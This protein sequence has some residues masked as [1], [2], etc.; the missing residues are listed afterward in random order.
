MKLQ[1][2]K[3]N[4]KIILGT[5]S[6]FLIKNEKN[7]LLNFFKNLSEH[8]L[9]RIDTSP[10]YSEGK[11]QEIIGQLLKSGIR[12][13]ITTKVF[14][15][16]NNSG[17][18]G[19]NKN[20]ILNSLNFSLNSLN[21]KK[22]DRLLMHDFDKNVSLSELSET[23][24]YLFEKN[25][26]LKVGFCKWNYKNINQILKLLNINHNK[27][28]VQYPYSFLNK[29]YESD[30]IFCKQRKLETEVY[31]IF[32]QGSLLGNFNNHKDEVNYSK[33]HHIKDPKA[34]FEYEKLI[35]LFNNKDLI[36]KKIIDMVL[37]NHFI[38]NVII[39]FSKAE[40]ING[41][42]NKL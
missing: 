8:G 28:F 14:A 7:Y 17:K 1:N 33:K 42:I 21:L 37:E 2:Y 35:K 19:L 12:Y 22:V 23:I 26:I 36:A 18:A 25:L 29:K 13:E 41:I 40:Q 38:D 31:G 3:I 10:T 5:L 32:A 6:P 20:N 4:S 16:V 15:D 30:L 39:G 24:N 11:T 27:I 34:H 9:K